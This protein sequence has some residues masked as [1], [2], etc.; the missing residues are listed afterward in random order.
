MALTVPG[1]S[2]PN[3][4]QGVQV[5]A[6][7]GAITQTWGGVTTYIGWNKLTN[8]P[9]DRV[10]PFAAYSDIYRTPTSSYSIR[11]T[12]IEFWT[13]WPSTASPH[14]SNFN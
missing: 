7:S 13:R 8:E 3:L 4:R 11:A 1:S 5:F 10:F 12:N 2:D 6:Q 14:P 9:I